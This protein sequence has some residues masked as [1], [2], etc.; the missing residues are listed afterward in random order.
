MRMQSSVKVSPGQNSF[1]DKLRQT[2][3][4]LAL[5]TSRP[6]VDTRTVVQLQCWTI[7]VHLFNIVLTLRRLLRAGPQFQ[8]DQFYQE[9]KRHH[10]S[11]WRCGGGLE[12]DL[13]E[14][15]AAPREGN[16]VPRDP[17]THDGGPGLWWE[18]SCNVDWSILD[19]K[20]YVYQVICTLH[21]LF[22]YSIIPTN[23]IS[24]P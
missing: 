10:H 14:E 3:Q 19:R 17:V 2:Q 7:P 13:Q 12:G 22:T 1:D 16:Q 11:L 24:N 4:H 5:L 23:V 21:I 18:A 15:A 6:A 20:D 9:E 8:N